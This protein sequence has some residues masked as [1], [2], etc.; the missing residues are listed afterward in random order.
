MICKIIISY[1]LKKIN[2][3]KKLIYDKKNG[4]K[5]N[6]LCMWICAMLS[7]EKKNKVNGNKDKQR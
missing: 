2:S 6:I 3:V 4:I 1:S 7:R 5:Q